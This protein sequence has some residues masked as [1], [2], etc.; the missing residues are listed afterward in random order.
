MPDKCVILLVEDEPSILR[1]AQRM[2]EMDGFE[3]H[4]AVNGEEAMRVQEEHPP[5]LAICDYK[6][7]D[8]TGE[9]LIRRLRQVQPGLPVILT[10]GFGKE[11]LPPQSGEAVTLFMPK[12]FS[13][14]MLREKIKAALPA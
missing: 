6:L 2:L 13:R 9:D 1:L 7:P 8:I 5:Q 11:I 3:V 14:D 4:G 10:S 12:P